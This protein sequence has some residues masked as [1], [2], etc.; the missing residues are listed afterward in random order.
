MVCDSRNIRLDVLQRHPGLNGAYGAASDS[1]STLF[2]TYNAKATMPGHPPDLD[3]TA[4]DPPSFLTE[5]WSDDVPTTMS[6]DESDTI[7]Y[8]CP[9]G[10]VVRTRLDLEDMSNVSDLGYSHPEDTTF[11]PRERRR[12][13]SSSLIIPIED[14]TDFLYG[15]SV[16]ASEDKMNPPCDIVISTNLVDPAA[17]G[18]PRPCLIR[19]QTMNPRPTRRVFKHKDSASFAGVGLSDLRKLSKGSIESSP[20]PAFEV[21]PT[22]A[23]QDHTHRL[24]NEMVI[25]TT[26]EKREVMRRISL[27]G[28]RDP[29]ASGIADMVNKNNLAEAIDK[30]NGVDDR[31]NA[32]G[33]EISLSVSPSP[34]SSIYRR[35]SAHSHGPQSLGEDNWF[36]LPHGSFFQR[37][38][39][40]IVPSAPLVPGSP[41]PL[42]RYVH[43]SPS[44]SVGR[45]SASVAVPQADFV[46]PQGSFYFRK[47]HEQRSAPTQ[48]ML[49]RDI[50]L[51]RSV[52]LIYKDDDLMSAAA[53]DLESA[54]SHRLEHRTSIG[55][56]Q[57]IDYR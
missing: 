39:H 44:F 32:S 48:E 11:Q 3:D 30:D 42:A 31:R 47:S 50:E 53:F 1:T 54:V 49:M 9:E 22:S 51:A 26:L 18:F 56:T 33:F 28:M 40:D 15:A 21:S 46:P 14:P 55:M 34:Q 4:K 17:N 7:R 41:V 25:E 5:G 37:S 13:D 23:E 57:V 19:M 52:Q 35:E 24:R 36:A 16:S 10:F 12:R 45:K 27:L 20:D 38:P 29:A 2:S 6:E 8:L 43:L